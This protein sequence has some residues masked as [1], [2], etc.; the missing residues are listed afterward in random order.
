MGSRPRS[1]VPFIGFDQSRADALTT[2]ANLAGEHLALITDPETSH[3]ITSR[4][5][6]ATPH[7]AITIHPTSNQ[8][9]EGLDQTTR[10]AAQQ[11]LS[12][13]PH[14]DHLAG[15]DTSHNHPAST[16]HGRDHPPDQPE[17]T[18]RLAP[19]HPSQPGPWYA[20]GPSSRPIPTALLNELLCD[21]VY[22]TVTT[23]RTGRILALRTTG[24]LATPTQL[25]AIT[26]RDR[27]CTFP[28]CTSPPAMCHAHHVTYHHE[29]GPT[30][31]DNLALLCWRHHHQIHQ[32]RNPASGWT[33]RMIN[34]IPHA[35]PPTRI[36]PTQTPIRNTLRHAITHAINAATPLTHLDAADRSD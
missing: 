4:P 21:A 5:A 34:A 33:L 2:M 19:A 28:N 36:D 17:P 1:I 15:S 9:V 31:T 12:T 10:Q 13:K 26:A 22:D 7:I 3:P 16:D 32:T 30:H 24:R 27:G 8:D 6:R 11:P 29:G 18:T 25:A 14:S 35:I 23:T 20:L